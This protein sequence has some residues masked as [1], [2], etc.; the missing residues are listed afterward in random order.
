[1]SHEGI[2]RIISTILAAVVLGGGATIIK[3][4]A[5]LTGI[6]KDISA[7]QKS[8]ERIEENLDRLLFPED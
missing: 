5:Q 6:E 7:I 1:M 3:H 2:I 4:E 8:Q